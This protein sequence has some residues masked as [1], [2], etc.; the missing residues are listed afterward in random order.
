MPPTSPQIRQR[1]QH[2]CRSRARVRI[3]AVPPRKD[4]PTVRLIT[5]LHLVTTEHIEVTETRILGVH[6]VGNFQSGLDAAAAAERIAGW[7]R[8]ALTGFP[9]DGVHLEV[10]YY[11]HHVAP[12]TPQGAGGLDHLD[13][14]ATAAIVGWASQFGAFTET[15]QGRFTQP[16]RW[17]VQWIAE[18]FGLDHRLAAGFVGAFFP[19]LL[20]Y[21]TD[22]PARAA[23]VADLADTLQRVR[24]DILI[25]HSLGSVVAYETLW[26]HDRIEVDLLV[27]LGSPLAM[28][29]LV[30]H[31]LA[32]HP[33]PRAKPP[34]VRRWINIA[35]RGD[36]I[37]IPSGGIP[38]RFRDVTGDIPDTIHTFDFH[39]ATHYL[40]CPA[41]TAALAAHV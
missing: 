32:A 30:Y 36:I 1:P 14:D 40:A 39:R 41:T 5:T 38:R 8:C 37:A 6:G 35:D 7:W 28:P 21:F 13:D 23:V 4:L 26:E 11:A 31:R 16:A 2:Y 24:P 34:G 22:T 29:D 12:A 19:E 20:R 27:T 33:G 10:F 3:A 15:P 17:G 18:H 9:L 25:A